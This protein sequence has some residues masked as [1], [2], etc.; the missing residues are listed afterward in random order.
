LLCTV[1]KTGK[2]FAGIKVFAYD[3]NIVVRLTP[4]TTVTDIYASI[5]RQS[6][7]RTR[8]AETVA[9]KGETA[10][11]ID[12]K[13]KAMLAIF[14]GEASGKLSTTTTSSMEASFEEVR[15]NL[16][17]PQDISE[18]VNRASVRKVVILESFHYLD[19]DKQKQLSFDL[20]TAIFWIA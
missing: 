13:V 1:L 8:S 12:S 3:K 16:E 10:A 14:G 5:L 2:D 11:S 6:G 9:T 20:R 17:L 18:L 19:D 4:K 15:F 7:I